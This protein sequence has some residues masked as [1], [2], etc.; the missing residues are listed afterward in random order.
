MI[1]LL[2]KESCRN[3]K[4]SQVLKKSIS[5]KVLVYY[6]YIFY[7]FIYRSLLRIIFLKLL[8]DKWQTS[9]NLSRKWKLFYYQLI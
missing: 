1:Y 3:L 9:S 7:N 4:V 2:Q 8:V 6:Y 5:V